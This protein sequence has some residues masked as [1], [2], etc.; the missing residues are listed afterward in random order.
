MWEDNYVSPILVLLSVMNIENEC[1]AQNIEQCE[2]S[3]LDCLEDE[4][5]VHPM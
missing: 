5:R 4:A 2:V 1:R 3:S